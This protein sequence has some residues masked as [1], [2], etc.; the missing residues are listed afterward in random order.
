MSSEPDR[1]HILIVQGTVTRLTSETGYYVQCITCKTDCPVIGD[2][3]GNTAFFGPDAK[4]KATNVRENIVEL[5]E[6]AEN[7]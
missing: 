7:F 3:D 6:R 5:D 1:R 2:Y 4:E